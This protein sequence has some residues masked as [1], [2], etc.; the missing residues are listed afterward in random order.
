MNH[1]TSL[2]HCPPF[3]FALLACSLLLAF[4][5]PVHAAPV[6]GVVVG[7][8]AGIATSGTR[9]TITQGSQNAAIQWQAFGI[10]AAESVQ[11][12][13]PGSSSVA[14]NRVVGSDPSAIFGTL[15]ANGQVFLVNPNGI[16]FGKGASVNVGGL[17]ASTLGIADADFMAGRYSFSGTG[18]GSVV[19]EGALR[20]DGGYVALLGTEVGNQG[21]ISARLGSV[22]L[23]AGQA[24]T[25]D[26]LGGNLLHVTVDRGVVDALVRNGGLIQADGGQ[27]LL[28]AQA[29]G[30][31]LSGAVNNT[32][33]IQAQTIATRNGTI[34]LLG[35]MGNGTVEVAGTLDASA[36][37]GGNGGF[38]ET[39]AARVR[40][41]AAANVTTAAPLGRT[42]D[43]LVDPEDFTIGSGAN[44]NISGAT[45]S[46]LLVTN[47]VTIATSPGPTATV[48]GTPPR[49]SLHTA[50]NGNGDI[51]VNEAVS[52]VAAP[53][54]TTL[55]LNAE[56]DVN[57]NQPVTAVNGNFVVCCGRDVNVRA[58][59]TTTSGSV[60]LSGGRNVVLFA[61]SAMTTT[62]GNM[63]I[64]A[65]DDVRIGSKIT[66]TRGSNIPAQSLGLD[67]G[68][69][70]I[71]GN[72]GDGPGV[73]AGTVVFAPLAPPATVTGPNAPVTVH[74]NP[75][76]YTTPTDYSANF[77]LTNAALS[78]QM[79]VY[80]RSADKT[81][82]G[83]T[84]AT[85]AGFR[86]N[87]AGVVLV[88]GP[89]SSANFDSAA[90]GVDKAISFTGFTL[91]GPNATAFALPIACCA[92]VVG[93]T[94]GNIIAA[95]L[96]PVVVPPVPVAPVPVPVVVI[97]PSVVLVT[98]PGEAV[99]QPATVMPQFAPFVVAPLL[100]RSPT[101][102]L[103]AV[104]PALAPVD[105]VL[106]QAP[107]PEVLPA[108]PAA[109]I[110]PA[111][112]SVAVPQA[113]LVP[114]V[115]PPAW[116]AKPYRN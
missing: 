48:A 20:A 85:L 17:V 54:T 4:G 56:R 23:A 33:V 46:A 90:V 111:G 112:A 21:T 116:R 24:I 80:P 37:N 96:P 31:M 14:L 59:I 63:T 38:I 78:Q 107:A 115:A 34:K 50:V 103:I 73:A 76:A 70:L 88:A 40:I 12:I 35:D 81:F 98:L 45:L 86:G 6:G 84:A 109:P 47:S 27:V 93:R 101:T 95:A 64:C 87:P 39:S 30:A 9:T 49:T 57:V 55:T 61:G 72:G 65:A 52:W 114:P 105:L 32:G 71:A 110:V 41:H 26:V 106:V 104:P 108:A 28:T 100:L 58:A 19:N 11:F 74:Y 44:D 99:L 2:P 83:T 94:M 10:G 62:D 8:S 68:L 51:N 29:A 53:S 67:P 18:R 77:I 66:L 43:W 102:L 15:S 36:P 7:G 89:A 97:P 25:L 22:A 13:Q 113:P 16:L 79:L 60:L 3:R 75:V 42:G 91:G 69:V 5:G 82:D 1:S 92:P